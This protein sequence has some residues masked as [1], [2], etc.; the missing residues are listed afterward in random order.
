MIARL[1][2]RKRADRF[3]NDVRASQKRRRNYGRYVYL[4][5][6]AGLFVYLLNLFVGHYFFLR[7]EGLVVSGHVVI[8]SPYDVQLT[9]VAVEP[10]QRVRTGDLLASVRSPAGHRIYGE[11]NGAGCRNHRE[12]G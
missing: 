3:L 5:A 4:A 2:E 10:G 12:A 1:H 7:A 8:A 6:V 9:Q 11:L